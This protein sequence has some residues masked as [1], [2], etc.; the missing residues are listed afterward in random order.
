MK[1]KLVIQY[2]DDCKRI[3]YQFEES[4]S[5]DESS[6]YLVW[7]TLPR[8]KKLN[9][10]EIKLGLNK[11][12]LRKLNGKTYQRDFP[13]RV[14]ILREAY[15]DDIDIFDNCDTVEIKGTIDENLEP[16]MSHP[17]KRFII[18]DE[19]HP[20][21]LEE[22][23]KLEKKYAGNSK[24]HVYTEENESPISL[25]DYRI[26]VEEITSIVDRIK[27]YG[28]SPL[29]AAVYAYD[30]ARDRF[31][32][33]AK[34][35][36]YTDSRDLTKVLLGDEI[37]CVGYAR[38]LNAILNKCGIT[39]SLYNVRSTE[40]GHAITIARI[41]DEKYGIDGIYYFDPT[42]GRKYDETNNH[43]NSYKSFAMTRGEAL[44]CGYYEDETFGPMDI[45]EY[46]RVA[47]AI[48]K[49]T[50]HHSYIPTV[51]KNIWNILDFLDG[52]SVYAIPFGEKGISIEDTE[53]VVEKLDLMYKL[54]STQIEPTK[55]LSAFAR[56]R[57]I[58]YYE[59]PDK[60]PFSK[61]AIRTIGSSS[62][63]HF[64]YYPYT[65]EH[66]EKMYQEHGEEYD[67]TRAGIDLVKVLKKV[68]EQKEK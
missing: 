56:V 35:K 10:T 55:L 51:Q 29:E 57:Q 60:F 62:K 40:E 4:L 44:G 21:T 17:A 8:G 34:S 65:D 2:D 6:D 18:R 59:N 33:K 54:L 22:V 27:S 3:D 20:L 61:E 53:D 46:K 7:I 47:H 1:G 50:P 15:S 14:E 19:E 64:S 45:D 42:R 9:P 28:L 39:S 49:G 67:R 66:L 31:Y 36:D 43:F 5:Y 32:V 11:Y 24:I 52:R 68:K 37:V 63:P 13:D 26:T 48:Q 25:E 58:E 23:E 16:I 41:K 30:Y 12:L 38:I